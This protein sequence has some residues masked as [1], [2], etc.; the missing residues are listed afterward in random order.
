MAFLS[1]EC[2]RD[3]KKACEVGYKYADAMANYK[4]KE[5]SQYATEETK[6]TTLV[7]AGHILQ[8]VDSSYILSD[9]PAKV[10]IV[11]YSRLDDSSA[12][13]D[14]RKNTPAKKN[15][16]FSLLMRK[17]NGQWMAHDTIPTRREP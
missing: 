7:M 17:R 3:E 2:K 12:V 11:K 10:E 14:F 6:N 16:E 5:A 9:T 4:V 1:T 8:R 15:F 13:I